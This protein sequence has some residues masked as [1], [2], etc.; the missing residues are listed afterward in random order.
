MCLCL[1]IGN[2]LLVR[3]V[4]YRDG[5]AVTGVRKKPTNEG[6]SLLERFVAGMQTM[7]QVAYSAASY[8]RTY[9]QDCN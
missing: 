2:E 9:P 4:E 6:E 7:L 5:T 8:F 3:A 1:L